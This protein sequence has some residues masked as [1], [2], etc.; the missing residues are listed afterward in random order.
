[1][2]RAKFF[3]SSVDGGGHG[4]GRLLDDIGNFLIALLFQE[5]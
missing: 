3:F 2:L 5:F 4:A 1:M